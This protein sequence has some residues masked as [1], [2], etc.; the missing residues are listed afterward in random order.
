MRRGR[1]YSAAGRLGRR[2]GI[3][4]DDQADGDPD[5]KGRKDECHDAHSDVRATPHGKDQG[6]F[7]HHEGQR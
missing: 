5:T 1:G 7:V 4:T 6:V 3:R 2:R